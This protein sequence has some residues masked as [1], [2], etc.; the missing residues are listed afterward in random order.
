[1]NLRFLHGLQYPSRPTQFKA[2]V[3]A[4][5]LV[6]TASTGVALAA[7]N[8][9]GADS[10]TVVMAS[11]DIAEGGTTSQAD[12][13]S[14]GD[15]V[16]AANP[17]AVLALGDEAYPGGTVSDF[18]TK[19]DP[20]WGSFKAITKPVPANHEYTTSPPSGYTGY[21]GTANVTNPVDGGVYYA[22][23]VAP[24]WRSYALNSEISMSVGS[25]QSVWLNDD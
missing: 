11:G 14:T 15:L 10:S 8:L 20:T 13:M 2:A 9:A 1:M 23:D 6:L 19:Y 21:F 12:A 5:I 7:S 4:I 24:G 3:G 16:R 18:A 25:A 22:F 17:S